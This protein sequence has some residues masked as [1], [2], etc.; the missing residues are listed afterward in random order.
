MIEEKRRRQ[1][2]IVVRLHSMTKQGALEWDFQPVAEVTDRQDGVILREQYLAT[3]QGWKITLDERLPKT[4]TVPSLRRFS[5]KFGSLSTTFGG[6]AGEGTF[7]LVI[8]K[9]TPSPESETPTELVIPPMNA[10]RD[11][12]QT[13]RQITDV[14][15]EEKGSLEELEAFREVL[16]DPSADDLS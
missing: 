10:L 8:A 11:L 12:V 14:S 7:V 13:V 9:A 1:I 5:S 3:Y 2:E 15:V 16:D 6:G 4:A